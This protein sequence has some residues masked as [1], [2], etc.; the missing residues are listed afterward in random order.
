[1]VNVFTA[2]Y[3]YLFQ[4]SGAKLTGGIAS[5]FA[6]SIGAFVTLIINIDIPDIS[7]PIIQFIAAFEGFLGA[8]MIAL[9][10]FTLT[11]SLN[12]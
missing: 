9:F 4:I 5:Y 12:R 6:L 1:M 2:V 3:M 8:F 11:R 10:V 7:P